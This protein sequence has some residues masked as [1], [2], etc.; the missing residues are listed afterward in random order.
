M[1]VLV[2]KF[3]GTSVATSAQRQ[4]AVRIVERAIQE[5]QSV[6]VVVSAMG[7][8]G[9]PYATDTLLGLLAADL[10]VTP[11]ERDRLQA[12]G[13]LIS[14]VVMAGELRRV[15]LDP[16]VLSGAEAGI[17]TDDRHGEARILCVD[18]GPLLT[19]LEAAQVPVVTGFQGATAAGAVTTL[20][21]GGSDTTAAALGAA[22]GAERVE[23]YTDVPGVMTADPRQV[24]TAQVV[25]A[26]DYEEVFQLASL[27]AKVVHPR[28]IALAQQTGTPLHVRQLSEDSQTA[29]RIGRPTPAPDL[30]QNRRPDASVVGVSVMP[31]LMHLRIHGPG[32]TADSIRAVFSRLAACG[33]S[34]DMINVFPEQ[35]AIAIREQ[36]WPTAGAALADLPVAVTRQSA[37]AKVS[38]VGTA[39]HGLPGVMSLVVET[40]VGADV[41]ILATS[42]SHQSISC[43]VP[44]AQATSAAQALHRVFGLGADRQQEEGGDR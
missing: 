19:H 11:A 6:V 4:V 28:A 9:D 17:V 42:D 37:T 1:K 24:P 8:R 25:A 14:A 26:A 22:L 5:G 21:R 15:G 2:Q 43:L 7:R 18:P 35:L 44:A 41:P 30:W 27:G 3:G 23:I 31:D 32:L 38:I 40:L 33:V 36:D 10:P 20:G 12:V 16:V 13:E 34:V 39:I 29:T